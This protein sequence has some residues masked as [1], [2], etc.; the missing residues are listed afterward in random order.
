VSDSRTRAVVV[1]GGIAGLTAAYRLRQARPDLAVTVVEASPRLGG[2]IVTEHVDGFVLEGGPDSLVTFK[3][4]AVALAS[5]L[6]L[7]PRLTPA[8]E[9][10]AGSYVVRDG[11]LRRLP[12]GL[13]GF[14]PRRL[15][16]VVTTP[17]LSPSAKLRMAL[18]YAVPA[19]TDEADES[20]EAFVTRR[21]G[22]EFYRRLVEPMASGIF[23]ADPADL[24][25]HA[26]MPHLRAAERQ[27]GSLT[28]FVLA[29]RRRSRTTGSRPAPGVVAPAGGLGEL[30]TALRGELHDVDVLTRTRVV[31]VEDTGRR[32]YRLVLVGP[33]GTHGTVEADA[34][35]LAVPA[36]VVAAATGTL[37]RDLAP[38]LGDFRCGTTVTVNLGYA[39]EHVPPRIRGHGYLVPSQEDRPARACTWSSAKFAGRAPRGHSLLRVSLGGPGRD[40]LTGVDHDSLVALA[41]AELE[42]TVGVTAE[43]VLAR[44]HAWHGVM[45]QYTV[46]HTARV[47]EVER[48]LARHPGV[49]VAGSAFHGVSVPDCVG[50]AERAARAVLASLDGYR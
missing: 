11:R 15:G 9:A 39:A 35:V 31:A 25:L 22:G 12:D 3:P 21:L 6:G 24:S 2:K 18:E 40:V 28:R 17:L 30:V 41:R 14:V 42:E 10:T 26:T 46:G 49:V 33:D 13:A 29:E 1:G 37:D 16:P 27:H 47:A 50:S 19:R 4:Q 45:P 23:G 36:R 48:V 32:R 5:E 34:V 43:P 20:L 38:V 44:V 7:A 8:V